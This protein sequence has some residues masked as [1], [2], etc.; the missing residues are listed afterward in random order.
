MTAVDIKGA[1]RG[2]FAHRLAAHAAQADALAHELALMQYADIPLLETDRALLRLG[3]K[4]AHEVRANVL[5]L[6]DDLEARD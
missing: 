4:Y 6:G 2:A 1:R 3:G 5:G